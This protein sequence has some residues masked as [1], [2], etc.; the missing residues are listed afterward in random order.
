MWHQG[1][2]WFFG[3]DV[4]T[5]QIMPTRYLTLRTAEDLGQYALSGVDPAW[6]Q[7]IAR[8]DI[9]VG[10]R[11]FG[12]GSSREHAPLGLL[13]RGVACVVAKSFSRIFYRNVVNI[14]LKL[15]VLHDEVADRRQGRDGWVDVAHGRLSF[16][17]G[18]TFQQGVMPAPIVLEIL[19]HGGLMTFRAA[20]AATARDG[21]PVGAARPGAPVGAHVIAT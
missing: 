17:G 12:C 11:N 1:R 7:R 14:G 3:D 21:Q 8:G 9:V 15:L 19:A 4:D 16:D 20:Q 6:P 5:D 18:A 2:C 13:G 10:G